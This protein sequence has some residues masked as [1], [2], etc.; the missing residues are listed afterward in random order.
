M[1]L[2]SGSCFDF[3]LSADQK[4]NVGIICPSGART[5]CLSF[6]I[7]FLDCLGP[8]LGLPCPCPKYLISYL[9]ILKALDQKKRCSR[10]EE[11]IKIASDL[12]RD[13]IATYS[14]ARVEIA[15]LEQLAIKF[16]RKYLYF[17]TDGMD[18]AKVW[19]KI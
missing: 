2:Y 11:E 5:F 4:T 18:N 7:K 16:P 13:H 6:S 14:G 12:K 3:G 10:T 15:R 17:A 9:I 19:S 1:H 8:L